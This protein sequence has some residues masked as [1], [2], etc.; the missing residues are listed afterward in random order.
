MKIEKIDHGLFRLLIPF[1]EEIT[2]T[3]YAVENEGDVY[4]I[5]SATYA[6][7]VDRWI[8]PALQALGIGLERVRALLLTHD[9][10]DHAGGAERLLECLP[11]A[12]L[13]ASFSVKSP[14][15]SMLSDGELLTKELQA[16]MLSGHTENSMAFLHIPTKTLLSGDCLQLKGIGKYR[17]GVSFP[18]WYRSSIR[19]LKEMDLER[20]VAAHEYDPLGSV[21]EGKEAVT[22]YLDACLEALEK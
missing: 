11:N 19:R 15:F 3:V 7:D 21:A 12:A 17:S 18:D 20:I 2:T 10:S 8:L 1:E 16:L 14:R 13:R 5:D 4:L 9:H 22:A 6:E